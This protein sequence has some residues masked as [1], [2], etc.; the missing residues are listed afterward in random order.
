MLERLKTTLRRECG[1]APDQPVVVGVSGGPD[2]LCLLD[3][4]HQAGY[5]LIVAHFNHCLRPEADED[6]R[7]VK[8]LATR[9]ELPFVM[10]KR[11]VRSYATEHSMGLEEAARHLRYIFLFAQARH[12]KAQAVAVGHTADDQ[13]ETILMH[14]LRGAGLR[15][16][17]GMSYRI[18]LP[19]FDSEIPLVRPLLDIWREETL[20]HCAARGLHPRMDASNVSMDFLR[21]RLRHVLIPELET[22]NPRFREVLW[23]MGKALAGDHEILDDLVNQTWEQCVAAEGE[24]FI[25]FDISALVSH[26]IGLQR[27]LFRR[28]IARLRPERHDVDFA[29]LQRAA[30]FLT[31]SHQATQ[32]DL[33]GGLRILREGGRVYIAIWEADLPLEGWPQVRDPKTPIPIT[34]PGTTAISEEWQ[35]Q[36]EYWDLPALAWEQARTS[37]NPFEV[38]MDAERL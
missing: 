38:W 22:Y 19:A 34:V 12:H 32:I 17:K 6:A 7:A 27:N 21:N 8:R 9:L 18:I 1:L 10:E 26:P 25:A 14:F 31:S 24:H 16:L 33:T 23:R 28:A 20:L 35:L 29:T 2:S 15:G 3:I 37:A 5:P 13:V 36:A 11:D 4:L 30:D